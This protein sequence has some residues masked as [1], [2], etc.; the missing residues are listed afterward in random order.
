[1]A[2]KDKQTLIVMAVFEIYEIYLDISESS[3]LAVNDR[4]VHQQWAHLIYL[5]LS[6]E[7]KSGEVQTTFFL[8]SQLDNGRK[9]LFLTY[10]HQ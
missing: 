7:L 3:I 6:A 5:T 10:E 8:I 2:T 9:S 4:K 1:M